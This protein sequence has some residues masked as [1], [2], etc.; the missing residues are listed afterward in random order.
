[1]FRFLA[2]VEKG[3]KRL[4]MERFLGLGGNLR[5]I[6]VPGLSL[7]T[8]P[9]TAESVER[10]LHTA[11]RKPRTAVARRLK[12]ALLGLQ[13]NWL[14]RRFEADPELVVCVCNFLKGVRQIF[15][16]AAL[17]AGNKRLFF[18]LGPL[19]GT[20]TVDPNGVNAM[21]SLARAGAP[22]VQ[23]QRESG[24]EAGAWRSLHADL[25]ARKRT[26]GEP[27]LASGR[28]EGPFVFVPL[29]VP[30]DSQLVT[31]G[32]AYRAV[33]DFVG[34]LVRA[35]DALPEGWHLRL[36][37]HP[38]SAQRF[39]GLVPAD[40][41]GWRVIFDDEADTFDLVQRSR[42]V[43]TVNSSVG[44]ESFFF[45]KPVL[46]GGEAFWN[47]APLGH[48]VPDLPALREAFSQIEAVTFDLDVRDAFMNYLVQ[49]YFPRVIM[50]DKGPMLSRQDVMRKLETLG[51][52]AGDLPLCTLAEIH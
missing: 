19:P 17:H 7:H 12:A 51:V 11:L 8:Y 14:R 25:R 36:K 49:V 43:L 30:G 29:Q 52:R 20:M 39:D 10:A 15:A 38:S 35:V 46:A 48:P 3:K 23:W 5:W 37:H 27:V 13:Y 9:E 42:A 6:A 28:G 47:F 45:D 32:G 40:L 31:F 18:E 22:Y 2:Y 24:V 44:L 50:G 41:K 1:M 4:L 34:I 16:D 21:N 26:A 33:E